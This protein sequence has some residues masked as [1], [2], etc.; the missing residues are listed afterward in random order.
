MSGGMVMEQLQKLG[1]FAD[2]SLNSGQLQGLVA[3][4]SKQGQLQMPLMFH[5]L[6]CC[7][8][9]SWLYAFCAWRLYHIVEG[10]CFR[11][12][13]P[14]MKLFARQHV[15]QLLCVCRLI[16]IR[17]HFYIAGWSDNT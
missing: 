17:T 5:R 1:L 12:H 16:T 13:L 9:S 15:M 8:R 10:H 6:A 7:I 2:G 3:A 11:D 14:G 4:L